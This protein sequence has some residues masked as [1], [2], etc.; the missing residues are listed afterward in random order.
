M[1]KYQVDRSKIDDKK[2]YDDLM[3]FQGHREDMAFAFD[4]LM[5]ITFGTYIHG[6]DNTDKVIL[7]RAGRIYELPVK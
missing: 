6:D 4:I 2:L 1:R 3:N 7:R 5:T